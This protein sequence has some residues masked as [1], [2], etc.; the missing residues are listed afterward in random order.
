MTV[1]RGVTACSDGNKLAPLPATQRRTGSRVFDVACNSQTLLRH[2]D[3]FKETGGADR[4][5]VKTFYGLTANAQG[6]L[7]LQFV[8]V[9]NYAAVDAIEVKDE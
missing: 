5:L 9:V 7:M 2:F 4:A 1:L 8:P 3:V 6:K